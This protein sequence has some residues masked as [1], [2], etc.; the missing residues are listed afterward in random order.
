[1][2][3]PGPSR[4][5]S[6]KCLRVSLVRLIL[7]APGVQTHESGPEGPMSE[8]GRRSVLLLGTDT[9]GDGEGQHRAGLSHSHHYGPL[10]AAWGAGCTPSPRRA[11]PPT[12]PRLRAQC[13]HLSHLNVP[14]PP[15]F[16]LRCLPA[17]PPS[18]LPP[19]HPAALTSPPHGPSERHQRLRAALPPLSALLMPV[20]PRSPSYWLPQPQP[21]SYWLL[22]WAGPALHALL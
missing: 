5:E 17:R 19:Q 1:M 18:P 10:P 6:T 22:G 12:P 3:Q 14:Q 16:P 15:P 4:K 2:A 13:P 21:P 9:A 20:K 8:E 7:P 11:P